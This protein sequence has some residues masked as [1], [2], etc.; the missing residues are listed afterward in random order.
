MVLAVSCD[1][2]NYNREGLL[3]TLEYAPMPANVRSSMAVIKHVEQRWM[4]P[5][6]LMKLPSKRKP[7]LQESALNVSR[8]AVGALRSNVRLQHVLSFL[9]RDVH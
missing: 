9:S 3:A 4:K 2:I 7:K 6:R 1:A 8:C 5:V